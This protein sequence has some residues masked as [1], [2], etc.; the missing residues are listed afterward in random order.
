MACMKALRRDL[1]LLVAY[2]TRDHPQFQVLDATLDDV[3]FRFFETSGKHHDIH[4]NFLVFSLVFLLCPSS[5]LSFCR[6]IT[7]KFHP[8]GSPIRTVSRS[9]MPWKFWPKPTGP[10]T[11]FSDR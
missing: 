6:K 7:P 11:T 4:A 9:A 2:F 5:Q 8:S 3:S 1:Q 10:T